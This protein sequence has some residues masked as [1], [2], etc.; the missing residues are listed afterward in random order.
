MA[1]KAHDT[2]PEPDFT[3]DDQDRIEPAWSHQGG[4]DA[5]PYGVWADL[6]AAIPAVGEFAGFAATTCGYYAT[7]PDHNPYFGYDPL[8][9]NLIHLVGFSGHGAMF[10]PFTAA[11]A[12][13]LAEAGRDL[14]AL[15]VDEGRVSLAAFRIGRTP[16]HAER[17]VI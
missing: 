17:L 10:G 6:A 8:R 16:A 12:A 13:A 15:A 7:T 11:V 3:Y 2:P 4:V 5:H 1:G 14:D 9:R